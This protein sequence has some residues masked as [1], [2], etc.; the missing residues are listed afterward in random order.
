MYIGLH[1]KYWLLLLDFN[2][3]WIFSTDFREKKKVSNI[4]FHENPSIGNRGFPY[5]GT[6]SRADTTKLI[7]ASSQLC[8]RT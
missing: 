6:D 7:V 4:K 8:E 2:G 3:T 1:V 5:E